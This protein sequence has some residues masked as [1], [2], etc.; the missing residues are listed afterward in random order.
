LQEKFGHS[1]F[2][3]GQLEAIKTL[4]E[5]KDNTMVVLATGGGKSLIYQYVSQFVPG[6]VLVV[7]PL[8]A[9][10][11][12]QIQKLPE[13]IPGACINHNQGNKTKKDILNAVKEKKIKVLFISPER[14]FTEDFTKYE[15]QISFVCVD[16]IHCAS[17]WSHNFRPAYLKLHDMIRSKLC[18]P[19]ILGLTA[20]ATKATQKSIA[21]MF[22]IDSD[23]NI[24]SCPDLS[25]LNLELSI[26]RDQDKQKALLGLLKSETYRKMQS[27]LIFVTHRRTAD[28][29]ATHLTQ[30]GIP[31]NSYHAGKMDQQRQQI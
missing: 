4:L 26:T 17:E 8:I 7:T 27:I 5:K 18:D 16:E 30:N 3:E 13:F 2:L 31:S 21:R 24:I 14:F 19:V 28:L 10:M 1:S 6:L 20:T 11:T 22:G 12:D 29:L 23:R 9:L 15:R 25:R